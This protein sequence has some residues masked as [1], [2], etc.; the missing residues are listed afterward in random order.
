MKRHDYSVGWME[1]CNQKRKD[2]KT[3]PHS[4]RLWIQKESQMAAGVSSI[5]LK[6]WYETIMV[7]LH[8]S[9]HDA[10]LL[11]DLARYQLPLYMRNADQVFS[12]V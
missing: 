6:V 4:L 5:E 12:T 7:R 9:V 3:Q 2:K 8:N 10:D 11:I 1:C